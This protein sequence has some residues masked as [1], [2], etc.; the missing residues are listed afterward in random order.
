MRIACLGWGSLVWDPRSL[1]IQR[2]WFQDGPF[3]PVEFTRKSSDGRVTLVIDPSAAPVR[4]LWAMMLPTDLQIAKE[5]LR[6]R[7]GI[8]ATDWSTKIGS[9]QRGDPAPAAIPELPTWAQGRGPDAVIWTALSPMFDGQ[10]TSP[11]SEQVIGYLRDL[12]GTSRDNAER[13]IRL[14]P[15]QI[16]TE[17]RRRIEAALG[18]SYRECCPSTT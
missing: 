5:A 4:L 7:E 3:A 14:T 17:Y 6:D 2:H 12:T 8:T 10:D 9:W 11:S 13:Y 18:W 15:R 16:D 1:P